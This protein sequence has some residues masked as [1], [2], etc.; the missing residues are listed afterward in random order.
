MPV[1]QAHGR[2]RQIRVTLAYIQ[3]EDFSRVVSA[4]HV[5]RLTNFQILISASKA[6]NMWDLSKSQEG[7]TKWTEVGSQ[8]KIA[9]ISYLLGTSWRSGAVLFGRVD[10]TAYFIT[11]V[12]A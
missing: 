7:V 6:R 10:D 8:T 4:A 5:R 9:K 3:F 1:I 11:L 2:W 12:T